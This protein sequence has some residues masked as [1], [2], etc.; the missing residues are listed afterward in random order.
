MQ[1]GGCGTILNEGQLTCPNCGRMVW[2][3]RGAPPQSQS[4]SQSKSKPKSK[5][6]KSAQ[7]PL[8][9]PGDSSAQELELELSE[10]ATPEAEGASGYRPDPVSVRRIL[11]EDPELLEKGL[12]LLREKDELVG[13][14]YP[15]D[16]GNIDLLMRDQGGGLVVAIVAKGDLG[17]DIVAEILQRIGWVRKYVAKSREEGVRGIVVM[18]QAPELLNYAAAAV[19]DTVSF[20]TYRMS[21]TFD[22]VEI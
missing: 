15:T 11:A 2:S 10:P 1:C 5:S 13:V 4:Q 17:T 18:D 7:V 12:S 3:R 14:D 19:A 20:R 9:D 22:E 8:A 6:K 16:V 21:L